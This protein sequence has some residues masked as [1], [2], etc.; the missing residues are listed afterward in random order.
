MGN[1]ELAERVFPRERV[2]DPVTEAVYELKG[3][4]GKGETN[5]DDAGDL[6]PLKSV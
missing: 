5:D 6:G 3:D 4:E 1:D 2:R